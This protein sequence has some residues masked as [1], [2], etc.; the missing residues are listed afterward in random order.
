MSKDRAVPHQ[1]E[2]EQLESVF[3]GRRDGAGAADGDPDPD[4]DG[5]DRPRDRLRPAAGRARLQCVRRRPVRQG[6][7]R[8]AARHH[9]RR[10]DPPAQRPRRASPP[11][12]ARARAG[13][14]AST[15]CTDSQIVVA[16]YCFGGQCALDLA[17]SGED[18]RRGGQLPRPVRSAGPAAGED[19][20]QGRRLPRLGRSDGPAGQGRR[21]GP[22]ADRGRL[23][24][25]RSTPTAMSATASPT[26]T[27]ATSRSTASP[28]TRSPPSGR[29]PASSTCSRNCSP[30]MAEIELTEAEAANR[31]MRLAKEIARHDKLYHD[32]DAPEI[33]DADYDALV[34][35]NRELE[36]RFP[37]L[38]RADSP[39][40]RLGA[41]PTTRACQGRARA[42]DA[43]PRECFF[44]TRRSSEFVARVKRFLALPADAFVAMTAEPKIDGLSCSLR[45]ERGELVLGGDARRRRGRRG[46]YRRTSAPSRD[47]PQRIADGTRRAR[48]ARRSVHVEGRLRGA[49]RAAG[50]GRRQDLRQPAQRRGR[51]ASPEGPGHHRRAAA[52]LPRARLG[53]DFSEPLA[54]TQFEAMKRIESFGIPGHRA[55]RPLQHARRDARPL[56]RDREGARRPAVRY[57]RRRLQ[58]RPARPAGAARL[59]RARAALGPRAQIPRREGRDHARSDRHPGRPHRQADA[60]RPPDAGR[61]RRRDRRQRHAPQ[62]RRDRAARACASATASA[63]SAPAT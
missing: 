9:V 3:V 16:G 7:P 57:R 6:I 63:S 42:A 44:G 1:F 59:R 23:A 30:R 62:P 61:R 18:I 43:Q 56:S 26:R 19:Q 8:R 25:G 47:I 28:T 27:R 11:S 17:R 36:E 14:R 12:A 55:A 54:D 40:K 51:L 21:A 45:Y 34:R 50:S 13:A 33:S 32:Q 4:R 37:Q 22:G 31:L 52:A 20:G 58:G 24:T 10:D 5:R 60:G 46:C 38:V 15:K 35:E 41:A 49:E 2:G 29:G 48:S 53:R 39:S